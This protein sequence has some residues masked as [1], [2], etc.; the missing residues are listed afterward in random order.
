MTLGIFT[1][2]PSDRVSVA[3]SSKFF[4]PPS[5]RNSSYIDSISK[6]IFLLLFRVSKTKIHRP[7]NCFLQL[8]FVFFYIEGELSSSKTTIVF[9]DFTLSFVVPPNGRNLRQK[10][11]KVRERERVWEN[12]REIKRGGIH[13]RRTREK[14][15]CTIRRSHRDPLPPPVPLPLY[16]V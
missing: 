16:D 8:L 15:I 11:E 13:R 1:L 7:S 6:Y 3:F 10:L 9:L 4:L 5:P 12:V 2:F 14:T